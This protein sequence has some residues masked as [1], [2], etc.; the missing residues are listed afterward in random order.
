MSLLD[1]QPQTTS[2]L[3]RLPFDQYGRY[4]IIR[5]GLD[6]ARPLLG[7][8][9]RVLDVGGYFRTGRGV[10]VLP[11]Q[12][13]LPADDVTVIDQ[14]ASGLPGYQ[15]GDG[16]SLDFADHTFDFVISCDTLEHVPAVDRPAF[17]HE[18][19]RVTRYGVLLAAPF[20]LPEVVAAEALLFDFILVELHEEQQ[21]LKEHAA[22]GLPD[23]ATTRALLD[24]QGLSYT[25]YPS[26]YIHAWLFM[27]VAKHY[28]LA[29]TD[30]HDLHEQVDAYYTRFFTTDERR[31]P[32]YRHLFCVAQ[33]GHEQWL[34]AT[35]A[36]LAPTILPPAAP[37]VSAWPPLTDWLLHLLTI[38]LDTRQTG[39][40]VA[41]LHSQTQTTQH[42]QQALAA[43]QAR[44][45]DL[46][47]RASWLAEQAATA[48]RTLA[49]VENGRLLR[50]L[51]W[52]QGDR[53]Q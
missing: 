3:L 28:L 37:G 42:L 40:L 53:R 26:G 27:M 36:A 6:A 22:Y 39:P 17:W 16:R 23:L 38:Q 34:A 30:N 43:Q 51:R 25:V 21:Q 49:A 33:P 9:F 1:A 15:R 10:E 44:A 35:D 19:L 45:D 18:L 41:A 24:D 2:Q 11:G 32:A 4:Q 13:F 20:S 29:R 52:L 8:S 12:L 5:E 47:R 7:D 31:E 46:E 14:V 48:Q 50:L